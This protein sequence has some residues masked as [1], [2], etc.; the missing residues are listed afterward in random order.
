MISRRKPKITQT[1][2]FIY[3]TGLVGNLRLPKWCCHLLTLRFRR[4]PI[5]NPYWHNNLKFFQYCSWNLDSSGVSKPSNSRSSHYGSETNGCW[6][7]CALLSSAKNDKLDNVSISLISSKNLWIADQYWKM[8]E[9]QRHIRRFS[10]RW[11]GSY[12]IYWHACAKKSRAEWPCLGCVTID[13][14]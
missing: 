7:Y 12:T 10:F 9:F 6:S 1:K 5:W 8:E 14:D 3:H 13:A 4:V 11:N 2:D